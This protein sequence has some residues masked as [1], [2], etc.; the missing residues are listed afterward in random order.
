VWK[1]AFMAYFRALSKKMP[2]YTEEEHEKSVRI[3]VLGP[4]IE[5]ETD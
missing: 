3:S 2:G 4:R 5:P 1:E